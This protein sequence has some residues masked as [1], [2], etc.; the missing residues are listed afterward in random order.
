MLCVVRRHFIWYILS[1]ATGEI[2]RHQFGRNQNDIPMVADYDG[3]GKADIAVRRQSTQFIYILRSSDNQIE[4]HNVG[5][6]YDVPVAAPMHLIME[7]V[8]NNPANLDSDGDGLNDLEELEVY[9]TDPESAD[10]DGDGLSDFDEINTHY[11][12]PNN[13]DSDSDGI[14]DA[15]EIS[16]GTD[17]NVANR[18]NFDV[19]RLTASPNYLMWHD[20]DIHEGYMP[21]NVDVFVFNEDGG[22][23]VHNSELAGRFRLSSFGWHIADDG[24]IERTGWGVGRRYEFD[25]YPFE[26]I[27]SKWGE[28]VAEVLIRAHLEGRLENSI[29]YDVETEVLEEKFNHVADTVNGYEVEH[30]YRY[31]ET[32]LFFHSDNLIFDTDLS[33]DN[34]PFVD[35][36]SLINKT[37]VTEIQ[38]SFSSEEDSFVGGWSMPLYVGLDFNSDVFSNGANFHADL[39]HFTSSSV[40]RDFHNDTYGW[41]IDNDGILSLTN[42]NTRL[43]YWAQRQL[44]NEY[45][46][47]IEYAIAGE[48]QAY[49]VGL[50]VKRS[51]DTHRFTDSLATK[52]PATYLSMINNWWQGNYQDGQLKAEDLFG[53]HLRSDGNLRRGIVADYDRNGDPD[54]FDLGIGGNWQLDAEDK[55]VRLTTFERNNS[56]FRGWT[57]LD[58][59][60]SGKVIVFETVLRL[61]NSNSLTFRVEPRINFIETADLSDYPEFW[62]HMDIDS[63]GLSNAEEIVYG[64]DLENNDS[65]GD[66]VSDGEE[67]KEFG[68]DPN[69]TDT[70][71]DGLTDRE[72]IRILGTDPTSATN[73]G[74]QVSDLDN[75]NAV[76]M[77]AQDNLQ[78]GYVVTEADV[79]Q[80]SSDG[81]V[82]FHDSKVF[83]QSATNTI[84]W[85]ISADGL[86][87]VTGEQEVTQFVDGYPYRTISEQYGSLVAQQLVAAYEQALI[88]YNVTLELQTRQQQ[89]FEKLDPNNLDAGVLYSSGLISRLV[90]PD[91]VLE[92]L[93][94]GWQGT[95][96]P[97]YGQIT[98]RQLPSVF[99][100]LD[101][102]A[103]GSFDTDLITGQW[104][105]PLK[106]SL[107]SSFVVID[108]IDAVENNFRSDFVSFNTEGASG[109]LAEL[110]FDWQIQDG[111]LLLSHPDN[112]ETFTY[113]ILQAF[114]NELTL[115]VEYTRADGQSGYFVGNAVKADGETISF[116]DGLITELP[117]IYSVFTSGYLK[118]NYSGNQQKPETIFGYRFDSQSTVKRRINYVVDSFTSEPFFY[119][120]DSWDYQVDRDNNTLTMTPDGLQVRTWH[121][122]DVNS[123]GKVIMLEYSIK[124]QSSTSGSPFQYFIQP[125]ITM[126]SLV[127]LSLY[128]EAWANSDADGDGLTNAEELELGTDIYIHNFDSDGDGLLNNDEIYIWGSDPFQVDTNGDGLS[129]YEE[130]VL[131]TTS[132]VLADTDAD[133]LSDY[134]EIN[135]YRTYARYADTDEDGVNDF[136]EVIVHGSDPR[137]SD[138]DNDGISDG[139]EVNEHGT[140]PLESDSDGDGFSDREEI[141]AGTDPNDVMSVIL[142]GE[143][144]QALS[145]SVS[146]ALGRQVI[147]RELSGDLTRNT[148][149]SSEFIWLLRGPV[150]VGED[151]RNS[152]VLTIEPGTI[153][154]GDNKNDVLVIS[155]GSQ[156]MAMGTQDAPVVMTSIEDVLQQE[157][158]AGQWGGLVLL[159]NAPTNKCDVNSA[160][161]SERYLDVNRA[162]YGGTDTADSSGVMSYVV[163]KHAGED[164]QSAAVFAGIGSGTSVEYLQIHDTFDDGV[165]LFGGNVGI[166][167]LTVTNAQDDS[168]HWDEGYQGKLQNVLLQKA[169]DDSR[170]SLAIRGENN[171]SEPDKSPRSNP[172][173]ANLTIIGNNHRTN[174]STARGIVLSQGTGTQIYNMVVTGPEQMGACMNVGSSSATQANLT[175]G[176]I[177]ISNS[178]MACLNGENFTFN[179]DSVD[180]EDW[181]LNQQR[182]NQVLQDVSVSSIG[183]PFSGSPLLGA[184]SDVTDVDTFFEL[185]NYIGAFGTDDWRHGW[186]YG[187]GG[188]E[189]L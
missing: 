189:V 134:D 79:Y 5:R 141:E 45:L 89:V 31:R 101:N 113:R 125:R 6:T 84:D 182:D 157:T 149:L 100:D 93:E 54:E 178:V 161:C 7:L 62:D 120:G 64:T 144:N 137:D 171:L 180:L 4:R 88:D 158:E 105:F 72:E 96:A 73:G 92:N 150:F 44:E 23:N 37:L 75:L 42:G 174:F 35:T 184:G 162:Y 70:D 90:I 13:A 61:S 183:I 152:A 110:M 108:G 56:F 74:F 30:L 19:Q 163:L 3:D 2:I 111:A 140:N 66:G 127:D 98:S 159:G 83:A 39:V 133:G 172:V 36:T 14:P 173:I 116:F 9:G 166:R 103:S 50:M 67:V 1:S 63:D 47:F 80:F 20:D 151:N 115:L 107:T 156:I 136:D 85:E 16:T 185:T 112:G 155:R 147:V 165:T 34:A 122:M 170:T 102:A 143:I 177:T 22:L 188:G 82:V 52:L 91:N 154:V 11:T 26:K 41:S 164:Y 18:V 60:E 131:Y 132:P 130:V 117:N 139:D 27:A 106:Y 181:F 128:D 145:D 179:A 8:Q 29:G 33:G 51:D 65:D 12:D 87:I 99:L 81:K 77:P 97:E 114:E 25:S 138:T 186:A 28:E 148:R 15:E 126:L 43:R 49:H 57:V 95:D 76:L 68:S 142:P 10:S 55:Q 175:N 104:A 109:L 46:V 160:I 167:Y 24:N 21:Q 17:P 59:T 119:L 69:D 168:L 169:P 38:S 32:L 78:T 176:N 71:N 129:D 40:N 123:N 121:V 86:L 124:A 48:V 187:F 118:S 135:V 94:G 58:V 146:L 53:F 153:L